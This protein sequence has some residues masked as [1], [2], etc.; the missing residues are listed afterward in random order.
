MKPRFSNQRSNAMTL[1]EV[2]V[3]VAILGFLAALLL[4]ALMVNSCTKCQRISCVNNLKEIDLSYRVWAG[5]HNDKFP[6]QVS[7]GDTNGSGTMEW[8]NGT[9]AWINYAV[10]ADVLST[11]KILI[12]PQ[13]KKSILATNFG[14]SF[15]NS[16]VSYF[17][18]LDAD[19][20]HPQMFL[21]GDDNFAVDDVPVKSGL[22]QFTTN[23]NVTWT[24]ERHIPYKK[25]FWTSTH[26]I[27][28]GNIALADGSVEQVTKNDL[29]KLLQQTGVATNRLAI[30]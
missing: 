4:P 10:M 18:G 20:D 25:H 6:M 22:A 24:S 11:P 8:A 19:E 27:F 7:I 29:Q 5:D 3:V 30:P 9:N 13:D 2:I 23:S 15:N 16:N 21:S 12:C 28:L 17:V 26:G 14:N 1:V